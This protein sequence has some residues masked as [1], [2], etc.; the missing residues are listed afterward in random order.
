MWKQKKMISCILLFL[1]LAV[2]GFFCYFKIDL[3]NKIFNSAKAAASNNVSGFAWSENIGWIS[4]NNI[5]DG[6]TIDYG[7]SID[8]SGN[9]S[10]SAWSENIGWVS[11]DRAQTGNPPLAPFNGGSGTIAQ[12]NSSTGYIT[13]WMKVLAN[14][15][16][17]DGWIRF[18]DDTMPQC[19]GSGQR[20]K[21]VNGEWTGWAW[22]D[23]VGGWVSLNCIN[24][25]SCSSSNY[26]VS[27]A[28]LSAP[29]NL[30]S[31]SGD[32]C[33]SGLTESFSW[34]LQAGVSQSAKQIQI[35]DGAT[36]VRDTGKISGAS[37]QS[38][39]YAVPDGT[40]SLQYGKTYSWQV[41]VWDFYGSESNWSNLA[42][43]STPVHVYPTVDFSW[44]PKKP[45]VGETVQF[46]DQSTVV[47]GVATW[48]WTF[49][50]GDPATANNQN[51]QVS[52]TNNGSQ[53][54]TLRVTDNQGYSC[55]ISKNL[56][57]MMSLPK[58][59]ET[60]PQ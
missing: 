52:F 51:P 1:L 11:F 33:T 16:G 48:L 38:L 25:S 7:V 28:I 35:Y 27:S 19:S 3:V 50:N 9:F 6:S 5:S 29:I 31:V 10:G 23:L 49:Q 44:A 58:W 42:S 32:Y 4:F 53:Q 24:Q 17:W 37:G 47:G 34:S 55:Q 26:K 12:Y 56:S 20:A 13:G 45:S 22:T 41:K 30:Q 59:K 21:I 46:A 14:G 2:M 8:S 15:G 43:F 57:S 60:G 54:V 18:C 40:F 36:L 39:S